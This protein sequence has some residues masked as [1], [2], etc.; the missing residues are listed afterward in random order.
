MKKAIRTFA[1]IF[2]VLLGTVTIGTATMWGQLY[3]GSATGVVT[4]ASG[5]L[6]PGAHVTITDQDRGT[7]NVAV[8]DAGGRYLFPTLPPAVYRISATAQGFE[9][10]NK[11]NINID[12]QQNITVNFSLPVGNATTV[13]QVTGEAPLLSTEDAST[14]QVIGQA[15]VNSLPLFN[16]EMMSLSYLTPGVVSP[17]QGSF[18]TGTY[19]NYFISNGGRVGNQDV[20]LDGVTI[21][22]YEQNGNILV[23]S[24]MPAPDAVQE[25]KIQTSSFSA[26][27][28][29]S[30]NTIVNMIT[31]SGGNT[32]HGSAYGYLRNQLMN[33]NN[34][35][36]DA[37]G[38]PIS[39][40]R[41]GNYGGSLG[42]PSGR[43]RISSLPTTTPCDQ[44]QAKPLP[45]AF[46]AQRKKRAI[47]ESSAVT[48]AAHSTHRA[49][50]SMRQI[51]A[52]GSY[53]TPTQGPTTRASAA[54][55]GR[56]RYRTTTWRPTRV[57][58]T[59]ISMAPGT[60][61]REPR[62]T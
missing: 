61:C 13:V 27:Y 40:S 44:R 1:T 56:P 38:V 21:T 35:F 7:A 51:R 14:G 29:F 6:I 2:A 59:Q 8:T 24:Y 46:P 33:A 43:I 22:N 47:L 5:A 54:H 55:S 3:T 34:W 17:N 9:T 11:G 50:A 45:L 26:E 41:W 53:T 4:D 39:P 15:L 18:Q 20:L 31:K 16:R 57:P 10:Q 62:E 23:I 25:F 32:F 19:G 49:C 60:N 48:T 36:N 28:G 58:A 37:S 42:G 52:P 12:V 30:G